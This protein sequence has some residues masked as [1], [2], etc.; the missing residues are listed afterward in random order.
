MTTLAANNLSELV[1]YAR[2]VVREYLHYQSQL[3][4]DAPPETKGFQPVSRTVALQF[5]QEYPDLFAGDPMLAASEREAKLKRW[6][7]APPEDLFA[8]A[9]LADLFELTT[10][11]LELLLM[12]AGPALDPAVDQLYTYIRND[13]HRKGADVGF[14]CQV[15]AMGNTERF[16]VLL[17]RCGFEAPLRRHQLLLLDH[18]Q[19]TEAALEI[20]LVS[21]RVRV[22]DRVLAFLHYH[23]RDT[24]QAVDED[25]ASVCMRTR[26]EISVDEL[27]LPLASR[28]ELL[29]LARSRRLPVVLQGPEGAGKRRTAQALA[30]LHM[31]GLLSADLTALLNLNPFE[32]ETRLAQLSREARLGGDLI[33]LYGHKIPDEVS[34][35]TQLVLERALRKE[36][37]LLGTERLPIW[38]VSLTE[39]WPVIS[40]PLPD[41]DR[42][43]SLWE[44]SFGSDRLKPTGA[45]IEVVA[46]RYQLT[47]GQIQQAVNE[48][49]RL[50]ILSRH[51]RVELSEL[52]RACRQHFAHQLSDLAQL[53][54]P[55]TFRPSD[56]IL[57]APEKEKF[58]EVLLYAE[59][60]DA[61]FREWG[62]GE[63]FPY[64]RGLS[65]LFFGPPGTGK[66]LGAM[67]IAAALGLDLFRVDLSQILSRYVGETEKNLA[68]IF[69][70]AE[71]GRVMLLFDEAD[72]MF[73]RRTEVQAAVDRYA[74]LEVAYLLQRMENFEGVTV[75]T[76]NVEQ[77]LDDAFKRRLRYRIYFP[78]PDE[79]LR[80]K[81]WRSLLPKAAPI[82]PD[83]P[84]ELLGK[85][86]DLAGGHI[87][88]AI[89]RSAIYAKR[90]NGQIGLAQLLEAG[91]AEC[92]ELGMLVSDKLPRKLEIAVRTERG[93]PIPPEL[94]EE[95]KAEEAVAAQAVE[96]PA[97]AATA[98]PVPPGPSPTNRTSAHRLSTSRTK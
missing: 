86:F 18:R 8:F 12:A 81:L 60:H 63:K 72:S 41:Y 56:L 65:I 64:G 70:E 17:A 6:L 69:D 61:I 57:P 43:V 35:Q 79:Q 93:E 84:F 87:K 85:H 29:L 1:G 7:A 50:A 14:L 74:N 16:E 91:Q 27:G 75:L 78:M 42:R 2:E 38:T 95:E 46:R 52:D 11:D 30:N 83:I 97:A 32:L 44:E 9:E 23:R 22:A 25:L 94:L 36:A 77:L 92:R 80:T 37:C 40:I 67:I 45:S 19:I 20:N 62:F 31:K 33:Y 34:G 13:V 59:Q 49:R 26:E 39:G 82:R 21:R 66:T 5:R 98:P 76:T 28:D 10:E 73:T 15:L 54:P 53:I 55:T 58:E 68:R 24:A 90:D 47:Q 89:L 4:P 71:K 48:S 96:T 3:A 88:Q 51:K